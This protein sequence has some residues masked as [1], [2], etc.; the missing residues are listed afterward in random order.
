MGGGALRAVDGALRG[1]FLALGA[2]FFFEADLAAFRA[3]FLAA[4]LEA[5]F[6][7]GFRAA[8]FLAGFFLAI[9]NP[10]TSSWRPSSLGPSSLG[11]SSSLPSSSSPWGSLL[12]RGTSLPIV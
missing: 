9:A 5:D 2:A 10:L 6:L 4:F 1:A 11:P 12:V 3:G 7:A 8:F